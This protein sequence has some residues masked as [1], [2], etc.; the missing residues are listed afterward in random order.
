MK[1]LLLL[2]LTIQLYTALVSLPAPLKLSISSVNFRHTLSWT[3][4]PGTPLGTQ[5]RV[6]RYPKHL[7]VTTTET[8]ADLNMDPIDTEKLYVMSWFNHSLSLQSK[9]ISFTP[10]VDTTIT[11]PHVSL[12]GCGDCIE[13]NITLP[14]PYN[15]SGIQDIRD[16]YPGL[17]YEVFTKKQGQEKMTHSKTENQTELI[18]HLQPYSEYCVQ[19]KP[20]KD[21][22]NASQWKC[23]FTSIAQ[24]QPQV[25]AVMGAVSV[26]VFLSVSA[27]ILILLSL[28]YAGVLCKLKEALPHTLN[29]ILSPSYPLNPERADTQPVSIITVP[30]RVQASSSTAD[31]SSDEEDHL[32]E[33]AALYMDRGADLSS[34]SGSSGDH[35]TQISQSTAVPELSES[36]SERIYEGKQEIQNEGEKVELIKN[37]SRDSEDKW[38]EGLENSG[39]VNLF[40]ITVA[41]LDPQPSSTADSSSDLD[42]LLVTDC[43]SE[44][45]SDSPLPQQQ[46]LDMEEEE[47]MEMSSYMCH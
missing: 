23:V 8:W 25:F 4:G 31:S 17:I 16:I 22:F 47:E 15:S 6:Y 13:V 28:Q 2:S 29:R 36:V 44:T 21:N 3:P 30:E 42:P 26:L 40:S 46:P 45:G 33:S 1:L 12:S 38:D 39:D 18:K 37:E 14:R 35:V 34:D 27:L 10:Y 7:M 11:A 5:Y 20:K 43:H 41:A 24:P 32:E 19:V 9:R